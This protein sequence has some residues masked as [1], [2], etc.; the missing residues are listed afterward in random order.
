MVADIVL[1]PRG[2]SV[3]CRGWPFLDAARRHL[4]MVVFA[5][6]E[7][8]HNDERHL[9]A[10][11]FV[12]RGGKLHRSLATRQIQLAGYLVS[13]GRR[14]HQRGARALVVGMHENH[15]PARAEIVAILIAHPGAA[16]MP[17]E[18][19]LQTLLVSMDSTASSRAHSLLAY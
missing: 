13:W 10:P 6:H 12:A 18:A 15:V 17:Y 1:G 3:D 16:L 11:P 7:D 2:L 8:H 19:C 9:E 4:E 5:F 14:S